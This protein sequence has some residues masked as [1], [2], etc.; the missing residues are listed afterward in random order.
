VPD[1]IWKQ[2]FKSVKG[3][4]DPA[5]RVGPEHPTHYCDIDELGPG[6]TTL[7]ALCMED[8]ANV[9]VATW[10]AFYDATGN[11][12][13]ADRGCLPFRIWQFYD[14]M[15]GFVAASDYAGYLCAAGIVSHYVGD[16]CQPLHGSILAD[17]DPAHTTEH[18]T[19][20]GKT[21][22]VKRGEGVH[23]V[24]EAKM[25]DRHAGDLFA[26]IDKALARR[27]PSLPALKSGHDAAVATVALMDR[28]AKTLP[29]AK[30]IDTYLNLG[31][32]S[33]RATIDGLWEA[34]GPQTAKIMADG[35]RVLEH[36]WVDAW[37]NGGGATVAAAKLGAVDPKDIVKRYRSADFVPSL[38]LDHIG[39]VL[40]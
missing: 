19:K 16:A 37:R 13:S 40:R 2:F 15:E 1:L 25:I 38:D 28:T 14:A 32:G 35:I 6:G 11:T 31:G 18:T 39:A 20:G 22:E 4:R 17:G 21:V 36:L 26:A 7:R 33:S 12:Q 34:F 30:L 29:P 8:P 24:F 27:G 10:Q 23:T 3:G 5:P 9:A